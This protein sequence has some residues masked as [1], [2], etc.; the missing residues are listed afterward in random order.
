MLRTRPVVLPSKGG[1]TTNT[2]AALASLHRVVRIAEARIA[3]DNAWD[4]VHDAAHDFVS[5]SL[6]RGQRIDVA[7]CLA[8][9]VARAKTLPTAAHFGLVE[10][11][12]RGS[13]FAGGA[14]QTVP[15]I[16]LGAAVLIMIVAVA[17]MPRPS[18]DNAGRDPLADSVSRAVRFGIVPLVA[19]ATTI[20]ALVTLAHLPGQMMAAGPRGGAMAAAFDSLLVRLAVYVGAVD[21]RHMYDLT[22]HDAKTG[23]ALDAAV[24]ARW[25]DGALA[26]VAKVEQAIGEKAMEAR[27]MEEEAM[28][29]RAMNVR[30][31]E[32]TVARFDAEVVR[33]NLDGAREAAASVRAALAKMRTD[34]ADVA[35]TARVMNRVDTE[36]SL[37][38]RDLAE[39]DAKIMGVW[40]VMRRRTAQ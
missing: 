8:Q 27:A 3:T 11:R 23:D 30:P 38:R 4:V 2:D 36:L 9:L 24:V 26:A 16:V 31:N 35:A 32:R 37:I 6:E 19:L 5:A 18:A 14:W 34:V 39:I 33:A 1:D 29:E 22:L 40:S 20:D 10:A 17:T 12:G 7:A 28:E 25:R 21:D 13:R 15:E